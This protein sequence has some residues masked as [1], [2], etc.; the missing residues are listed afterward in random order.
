MYKDKTK[1]IKS[2]SLNQ[3]V[4]IILSYCDKYKMDI[5][6][7]DMFRWMDVTIQFKCQMLDHLSLILTDRLPNLKKIE[8]EVR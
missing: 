3:V 8:H 1:K 6:L 5:N 2:F 4:D 7:R